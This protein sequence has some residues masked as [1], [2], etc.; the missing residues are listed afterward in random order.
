MSVLTEKEPSTAASAEATETS[1]MRR[2]FSAL[3]Y[4]DFRLLWTGAFV[5]TT[6]TWMQT[7]AQSWVVLSMT[8]SALLLGFDAFLATLP[9]I[10]FSLLGGV[11]RRPLRPPASI[12][13]ALPVLV[14][15]PRPS[16]SRG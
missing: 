4:R 2:M 8:G 3:H 12:L 15:C 6:G 11:A 7:V 10:F 1:A 9:M 16:F 13:L 5:S 14:R